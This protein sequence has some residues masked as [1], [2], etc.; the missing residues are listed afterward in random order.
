M[1]FLLCSAKRADLPVFMD[2]T[3]KLGIQVQALEA[4]GPAPVGLFRRHDEQGY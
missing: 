2:G 1:R 3:N 4:G